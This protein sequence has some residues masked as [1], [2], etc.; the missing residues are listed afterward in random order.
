MLVRLTY[1][2][3]PEYHDQPQLN[4]RRCCIHDPALTGAILNFRSPE[5]N[6]LWCLHFLNVPLVLAAVLSVDGFRRFLA[7][8]F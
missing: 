2:K 6:V 1:D 3:K 5:H 7:R 4:L 8:E